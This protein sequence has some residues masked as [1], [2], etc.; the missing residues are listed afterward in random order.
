[1]NNPVWKKKACI[2]SIYIY[3][4]FFL[5][6]H[7]LQFNI[8]CYIFVF[9]LANSRARAPDPVPRARRHSARSRC[10]CSAESTATA[11]GN[12]RH[13]Y[14]IKS[15]DHCYLILFSN[16]FL[17]IIILKKRPQYHNEIKSYFMSYYF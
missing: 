13:S 6:N 10:G 16:M 4:P 1:M 14:N 2:P 5:F 3:I 11:E 7:L 17:F 15:L 12:V 9:P 8:L